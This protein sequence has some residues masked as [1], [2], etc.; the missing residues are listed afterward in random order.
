MTDNGILRHRSGDDRATARLK[1]DRDSRGEPVEPELFGK[2]TEHLGINVYHGMDA[3]ILFNPTFGDWHFEAEDV[4][5]SGG[6]FRASTPNGWQQSPT[7]ADAAHPSGTGCSATQTPTMSTGWSPLTGTGAPSGGDPAT[8][9]SRPA[10]TS[11]RTATERSASRSSVRAG[12]GYSSAPTSRSTGRA[13]SRSAAGCARP[14]R[15]DVRVEVRPRDDAA[16][17]AGSSLD[18]ETDWTTVETTV[19]LPDD[20]DEDAPYTVAVTASGGAAIVVDRVLICSDDHVD[21]ADPDVIGFLQGSGLPLLRLPG[22][23]FAS[24]YDWR[25]GVGPVDERPTRPNP[26][27]HGLKPNLFG[28]QEFM[29]LCEVV[30]CEPMVCV[31]A[32]SGIP[33]EAAA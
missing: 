4:G 23:N 2:F 9:R 19:E 7:T 27:W 21:Y 25:D 24:D 29:Q 30:G 6:V 22:G 32:G 1:L 10:R 18:A 11:P 33:A 5:P 12:Q 3:Q 15:T 26:A 20:V 14:S 13:G 28:I 17:L 31:N 16:P 8:T